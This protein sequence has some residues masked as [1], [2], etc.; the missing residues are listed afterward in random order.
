MPDGP[1]FVGILD[2]EPG[3]EAVRRGLRAPTSVE[4]AGGALVPSFVSRPVERG[5]L[6]ANV[7]RRSAPRDPGRCR[8]G[9]ARLREQR[10]NRAEAAA[11]RGGRSA[12]SG[13]V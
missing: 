13:N 3:R 11:N 9:C 1:V 5:A 6:L 12:D 8:R 7:A 10:G 4:Q 2:V